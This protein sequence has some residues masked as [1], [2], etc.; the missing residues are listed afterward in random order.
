[1]TIPHGNCMSLDN[2]IITYVYSVTATNCD[3]SVAC[4]SCIK[5]ADKFQN[6]D[7]ASRYPEDEVCV[8][9]VSQKLCCVYA[10]MASIGVPVQASLSVFPTYTIVRGG[11]LM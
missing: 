8:C 6:E 9:L 3:L 7:C 4:F 2:I 11:F 5:Y 1:M 10:L